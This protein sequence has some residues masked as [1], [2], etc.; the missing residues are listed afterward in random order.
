MDPARDSARREAFSSIIDACIKVS[1]QTMVPPTSIDP[2]SPELEEALANLMNKL[3]KIP[4]PSV[5]DANFGHYVFMPLSYLLNRETLGDRTTELVLKIVTFLIT[6]SW[7]STMSKQL[8]TQLLSLLTY[9]AFG[10]PPSPQS[11]SLTTP[12][13]VQKSEPVKSA[14]CKALSALYR[15]VIS[16]HLDQDVADIPTIAYNITLFLECLG[17]GSGVGSIELQT[18]ALEVLDLVLFGLIRQPD[19]LVPVLP[20]VISN[21]TKLLSGKFGKTNYVVIAPSIALVAKLLKHEFSDSDLQSIL[22]DDPKEPDTNTKPLVIEHLSRPFR[23]RSWLKATKEQIRMA[24]TNIIPLR[25]HPRPEVQYEMLKLA[26]AILEHCIRALDSSIPFILDTALYFTTHSDNQ[27]AQ[28]AKKSLKSVVSTSEIARSAL[29]DRTHEWIESLTRVMSSADDTKPVQTLDAIRGATELLNHPPVLS[30]MLSDIVLDSLSFKALPRSA[31]AAC[32]T[33]DS[34]TSLDLVPASISPTSLEHL[35]IRGDISNRTQQ[36]LQEL[37]ESMGRSSRGSITITGLLHQVEESKAATSLSLSLSLV[38]TTTFILRGLL[39]PGSSQTDDWIV[40][41]TS[42]ISPDTSSIVT[43]CLSLYQRIIRET[44]SARITRTDQ[45]DSLSCISLYGISVISNHMGQSFRDELI[46]ILYPVVEMLGYDNARVVK[47]AQQAILHIAKDSGYRNIQSLLVE[48]ADYLVDEVS[49]KL[50]L[51]DFSP[52]TPVIL[53]TLVKLGGDKLILYMDDLVTSIFVILDNYHQYTKLVGGMF[54]VFRTLVQ[55]MKKGYA[56]LLIT[57]GEEK[58]E[59]FGD[60]HISTID[61]LIAEL[62]RVV[63]APPLSEEKDIPPTDHDSSEQDLN[64]IPEEAI[65]TP[66]D[67]AHEAELKEW[68]Y[69]IAKSSYKLL[70]R[71]IGYTE[72]YLTHSSPNLRYNLIM[73]LDSSLDVLFISQEDFLPVINSFWPILVSRIQ[74]EELFV[75]EAALKCIGDTCRHGKDFMTSRIAQLWPKLKNLFPK[76][77]RFPPLSPEGRIFRVLSSCLADIISHTQISEEI[78]DDMLTTAVPYFAVAESDTL[79]TAFDKV[80]P[81]ALWMETAMRDSATYKSLTPPIS[82]LSTFA[83]SPISL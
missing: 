17:S 74:D 20:G 60:T 40:D 65:D 76:K 70:Q 42:S 80:N 61:D 62:N 78:F 46:D 47:C 83:F 19:D 49:V 72:R 28:N 57:S 59:R 13:F 18:N 35:S 4:D 38:W 52:Q 75:V 36:S 8:A 53:S 26:S 14:G 43:N 9:L 10:P 24:L 22:R 11:K 16:R 7:Q 31:P 37:L 55:E 1:R 77:K 81:D 82:S 29:M 71:I 67:N 68:K 34:N 23:T 3:G 27:L 15:A 64:Y 69:P 30:S 2:R 32:E 63:E 45:T 50:N 79:R 21:L 48:N 33:I 5:L 41:D 58:K 12:Q 25:H 39:S 44:S 54:N 73:T 66:L 6:Y 51:L 56:P